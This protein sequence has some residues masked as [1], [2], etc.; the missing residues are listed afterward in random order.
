MKLDL[1]G[2]SHYEV[3]RLLDE[4]IW[5]AMK[6]NLHDIEI[7]TGNSSRMKEFVIEVIN[8][9][10]LEYEIGNA[11]NSGFIRVFLK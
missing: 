1:H 7:V 8:E 10:Q 5:N 9:Y 3:S 4:F 6:S 2:K 11:W